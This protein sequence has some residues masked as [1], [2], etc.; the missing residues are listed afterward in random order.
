MTAVA[1]I[2][3][4]AAVRVEEDKAQTIVGNWRRG[5]KKYYLFRTSIIYLLYL[6]VLALYCSN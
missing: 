6:L 5:D 4:A 2:V 3:I 1:V